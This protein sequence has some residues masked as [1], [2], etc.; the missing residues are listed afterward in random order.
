[1]PRRLLRSYYLYQALASCNF[2]SPVFYVYYGE[3]VGLDVPAILWIQAYFLTVRALLEVPFGALA[4]RVSRRVCLVASGLGLAAGSSLLVAWPTVA[5]VWVAETLFATS[6]AL[7]SGADSAFLFDALEGVSRLDL[8]PQTESRGQAVLS[9]ATGATAV[10]GGL[11]A[12]RDLRLPYVATVLAA[13]VSAALATTLPETRRSAVVTSRLLREAARHALRAPAVRWAIG[14]A[15][16]AVVTS[17]VYYYLQQP[18]LEAVAVPI[19]AFG[20]VFAGT[21]LVTAVVASVAHRVD[22]AMAPRGAAALMAVVSA[23]GLLAMSLATGP[24]GA[25]LLLARGVLDGLWMPLANLYLNRLVTSEARATMLSLQA[26]VARLAL[27]GVIAVLG[28]STRAGGLALT[29][30][31]AAAGT[32]LAGAALLLTASGPMIRRRT[33]GRRH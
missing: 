29:L 4:D 2:F 8:Y 25:A 6:A 23:A 17:H 30:A 10:V 15:A 1:V 7:R 9:L 33:A 27:A 28:A 24:F 5:M 13:S 12:A 19:A 11:L 14:L 18:F 16:F 3:R 21:K 20:L 22:A 26:L 31:A 32:A